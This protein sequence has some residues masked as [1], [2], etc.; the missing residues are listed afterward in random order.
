MKISKIRKLV[1]NKNWLWKKYLQLADR[2]K[3]LETFWDFKCS[4]FFVGEIHA[5][6]NRQYYYR[7]TA[8]LERHVKIIE[9]C[10]SALGEEVPK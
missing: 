4:D 8:R 3:E 2:E 5:K 1:K 6:L 9:R 10:L 7:A